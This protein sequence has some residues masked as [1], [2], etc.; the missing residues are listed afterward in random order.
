VPSAS[1]PGTNG[2]GRWARLSQRGRIEVLRD[3][4]VVLGY[5]RATPAGTA[6][7]DP[8]HGHV[9]SAFNPTDE[10]RLLVASFFEAG[11]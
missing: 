5:E 11:P 9:H 2:A 8:G 6:S 3:G 10:E 4:V 7:V 1:Q